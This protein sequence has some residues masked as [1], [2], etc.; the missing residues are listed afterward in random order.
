MPES[1]IYALNIGTEGYIYT[2]N[3]GSITI[4]GVGGNTKGKIEG[5]IM[6]VS[7]KAT[8]DDAGEVL[9][10]ALLS[11]VGNA[12]NNANN[13]GAISVGQIDSGTKIVVNGKIVKVLTRAG[14]GDAKDII[15]VWGPEK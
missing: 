7:T 15:A 8:V 6:E 4:C 14:V 10:G 9:I 12:N 3:V 13:F 11:G 2:A 5:K 1:C